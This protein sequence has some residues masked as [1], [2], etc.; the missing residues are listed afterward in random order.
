LRG[1]FWPRRP[2]ADEAEATRVQRALIAALPKT[3]G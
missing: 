2:Y 3:P 1:F